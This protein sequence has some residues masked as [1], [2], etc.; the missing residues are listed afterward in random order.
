MAK[1]QAAYICLGHT[2][3]ARYLPLWR[4]LGNL[5]SCS[6]AILV[7][8]QFHILA[9]LHSLILCV[10]V[11][12]F[13]LHINRHLKWCTISLLEGKKIVIL[14]GTYSSVLHYTFNYIGIY[15][16]SCVMCWVS[17]LFYVSRTC[18]CAGLLRGSRLHA[19]MAARSGYHGHT[20]TCVFEWLRGRL[21][22]PTDLDLNP[23]LWI[24]ADHLTFQDSFSFFKIGRILSTFYGW[25]SGLNEIIHI[26]NLL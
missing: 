16:F 6:A 3:T 10:C 14:V 5:Y 9:Y 20:C 18:A 22:C 8:T 12:V 4:T 23:S 17:F 13:F 21:C 2:V 15:V 1:N 11:C 19:V 24:W 7:T 25:F 26:K